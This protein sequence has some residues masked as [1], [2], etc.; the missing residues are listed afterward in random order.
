MT[1][2]TIIPKLS[3]ALAW[4]FFSDNNDGE[5]VSWKGRNRIPRNSLQRRGW[6]KQM[7]ERK[8]KP[9]AKQGRPKKSSIFS[10]Q[11]LIYSR[12]FQNEC[13][14]YEKVLPYAPAD[15]DQLAWW[16]IHQ[17]ALPLLAFMVRV[18]F[19]IPVASSKSE[20]VFSVAGNVVTQKRNRL[21]PEKVE[22]CVIVKT[23]LSLLREMGLKK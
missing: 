14:T 3:K 20:R 23:N 8:E 9:L 15:V 10:K 6:K 19:A 7:K 18:T 22:S 13:S 12:R 2:K 16:K 5:T 11:S 4:K 21:D 1:N 17:E